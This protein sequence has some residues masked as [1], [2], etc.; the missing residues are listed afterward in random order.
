MNNYC[1]EKITLHSRKLLEFIQELSR[2]CRFI[3]TCFQIVKIFCH[4]YFTLLTLFYFYSSIIF[5]FRLWPR[6]KRSEWLG[7]GFLI[8]PQMI[9]ICSKKKWRLWTPNSEVFKH[10]AERATKK[11]IVKRKTECSRQYNVSQ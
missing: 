1:N 7:V 11:W 2:L 10:L 9:I 8:S 6:M 3:I 4:F 5:S